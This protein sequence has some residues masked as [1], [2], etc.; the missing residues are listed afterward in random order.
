MKIGFN[1][2]IL[3]IIMNLT[4]EKLKP[5]YLDIVRNWRNSP[6]ISKYMYTEHIISENEHKTWFQNSILTKKQLFW[7]VILDNKPVGAVTIFNIDERKKRGF[8]GYYLAE[9]ES[10]GKGLGKIIEF[11]VMHYVFDI[12]KMNKLCCE[13]LS[14]NEL[15]I[16]I[17]Q[18]YGSK[19]EGSFKQHI[20]KNN[21][22]HDIVC[23]AILNQEWPRI[24]S[25]HEVSYFSFE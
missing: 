5:K 1:L 6:E 9:I 17:H 19:I 25:K 12:L 22:Y 10:R 21:E 15:V 20:F 23:M 14:F 2:V 7:V 3:L 4:F 24:K 11:N 13:V 16:K 8:W 18:K